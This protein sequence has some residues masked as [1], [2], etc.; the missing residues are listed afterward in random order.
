MRRLDL[1]KIAQTLLLALLACS[2]LWK[3]GKA[4]DAVWVLSLVSAFLTF[5]L[6]SGS[7][8]THD[9]RLRA[10]PHHLFIL[11]MLF[12]ALTC[13]SFALSL[14]Y[15]YGLDEVFQT[16][17]LGLLFL[18]IV[19]LNTAEHFRSSFAR[20]LSIALLLS[21]SIGFIVYVFQPV[22]RF[23]GTFFDYRFHTDYWPNAWGE[24]FLLAWPLLLW[25]LFLRRQ[26]GVREHVL[27]ACV[28]GV[29]LGGFFLSYSRGS[30][31]AFAGQIVL[32]ALLALYQ[33]RRS[34]PWACMLSLG[35][36]SLVVSLVTFIGFNDLRS[37]NFPVESVLEKATFRS[38]EGASSINER[39]LFF[40]QSL[41]LL[42]L[43]PFLGYG[44]YAFRFIQPHVQTGVLQTSDHPHNVFLKLALE[45]GVVTSLVF[46]LILLSSLFPAVSLLLR[47][48]GHDTSTLTAVFLV[49]TLGV[50]AHNL[51]D[52]NLQFVGI[53]LPFW[54]ILGFLA[55]THAKKPSTLPSM[56]RL[57]LCVL[58]GIFLVILFVEG[59]FLGL[60]S[61]A[62]H[63]EARGEGALAL[64]Y[65]ALTDHSL[66]PRDAWLS[67]AAL[68]LRQEK[69]QDAES[70]VSVYVRSNSAD[71]RGWR[72]LGDIYLSWGKRED[73][74]RAYEKA[75]E[76]GRWNDAGI[77]RGLVYLLQSDRSKLVLRRHE[78]DTLLN[79]YAFAI[80]HNEHFIALGF[81]VEETVSLAELLGKIFQGDQSAY[82]SLIDRVSEHALLE[83]SV[84]S[85]RPTGFLW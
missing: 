34:L 75:Y 50:L 67:R 68:L 18:L 36:L 2:V 37:A 84:Y 46:L 43:K 32:F 42:R 78:I 24:F 72:L 51:I 27:S 64:Q 29:A 74:L 61:L 21:L 73:A 1:P 19:S 65:Y 6:L 7:K 69:Y 83:R 30:F 62:R 3:G 17:A 59:F 85:S 5:L 70:A 14:T 13:V 63:S 41:E 81:N 33:Y 48:S 56:Q 10:I 16:T 55:S 15:N 8:S 44:P 58:T 23:V 12:I 76:Y 57:L 82:R 9:A 22:S 60:S 39:Q 47:K 11:V 77:I 26:S 4:L 38:S 45:R 40:E 49:S 54:M 53:A 66:F 25:T 52:Y 79:E 31:I 71:A 35:F 28:F 80:E 20:V